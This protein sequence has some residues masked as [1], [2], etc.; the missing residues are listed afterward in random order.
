MLTLSFNHKSGSPLTVLCLGAHADDIEIG[1]GGTLLKLTELDPNLCVHW[2]VLSANLAR[3]REARRGA[4]LF[5]RNAR[6]KRLVIRKFRD[7]YFPFAGDRIK[8]FVQQLSQQIS[9]DIIF[10]HHRRDLHQDHRLIAELTW[11]AFRNHLIL[12]Y[13]IP[14]YDGDMGTPNAYVHVEKSLAERK[15]HYICETFKTQKNKQWFDADTF[16]ALLRLRGLES[17]SPSKYAEAFYCP[18]VLIG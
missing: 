6:Q 17:N 8:K 13:E 10:T 5:L 18:K 4:Q 15:V 1:C 14:K 12:E 11:N 16:L 3:T 9:P 7:S 2:I